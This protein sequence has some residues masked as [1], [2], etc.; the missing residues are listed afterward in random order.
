MPEEAGLQAPTFISNSKIL[1]TFSEK[2]NPREDPVA[3]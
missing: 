2:K 3:S 1:F